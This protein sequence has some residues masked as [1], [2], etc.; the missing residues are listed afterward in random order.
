MIDPAGEVDPAAQDRSAT[1]VDRVGAIEDAEG[2]AGPGGEYAVELPSAHY[3]FHPSVPFFFHPSVRPLGRRDF[4]GE[5][6]YQPM[7]YVVVRIAI[8]QVRVKRIEVAEV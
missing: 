5:V 3:V 4:P 2:R 1:Y 8:V 6:G 7:T